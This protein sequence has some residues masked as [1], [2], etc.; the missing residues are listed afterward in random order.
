MSVWSGG[1]GKGMKSYIVLLY[2]CSC[3]EC[4]C[5]SVFVLPMECSMLNEVDCYNKRH[6]KRDSQ[7]FRTGYQILGRDS[8]CNL[9]LPSLIGI[10]SH[11]ASWTMYCN[12]NNASVQLFCLCFDSSL[13]F[14]SDINY[15]IPFCLKHIVSI[16]YEIKSALLQIWVTF[17]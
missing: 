13:S 9:T 10:R 12:R 11:S 1:G 16:A 6:Y 8:E 5:C 15:I 3:G 4:V 2:N 14:S 17:L 7:L